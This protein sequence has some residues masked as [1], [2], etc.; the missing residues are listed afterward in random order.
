MCIKLLKKEKVFLYHQKGGGNLK[1]SAQYLIIGSLAGVANGL[2]GSGGGLFL[3]P[4][5]TK[6]SGL[7]QKRA[8]ATSVAV[9]V[10]LSAVSLLVF[11]WRGSLDFVAALPYLIGGAV[12][13]ILSG[14]FFSKFS[15]TLLRRLFGILLIYGGIRAVFLW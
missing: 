11:L 5:L 3:V 7:E 8:F 15:A 6:W 14:C 10:P 2:F 1:K 4:L 12:G 9:V 13:G